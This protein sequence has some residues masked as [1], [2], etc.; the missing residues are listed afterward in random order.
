MVQIILDPH[1]EYPMQWQIELTPGQLNR[2]KNMIQRDIETV[3]G[4]IELDGTVSL[5]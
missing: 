5:R 3:R 4:E 2:L 1:S